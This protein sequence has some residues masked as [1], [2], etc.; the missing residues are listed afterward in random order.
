MWLSCTRARVGTETVRSHC[1]VNM[2]KVC[3]MLSIV[4]EANTLGEQKC[5]A[6]PRSER[7]EHKQRRERSEHPRQGKTRVGERSAGGQARRALWR[8]GGDGAATAKAAAATKRSYS[9]ATA[10]TA[11]AA[12]DPQSEASPTQGGHLPHHRTGRDSARRGGG[13]GGE[14]A[15][16]PKKTTASEASTQGKQKCAPNRLGALANS[17]GAAFWRLPMVIYPRGCPRAFETPEGNKIRGRQRR[18]ETATFCSAAPDF[19]F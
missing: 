19:F 7:S 2:D 1:G 17:R 18:A 15:G 10:P 4:S 16:A 5:D 6:T 11:G 9:E 3:R 12:A 13:A 8:R 14:G